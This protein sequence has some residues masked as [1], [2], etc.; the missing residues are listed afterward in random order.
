M[1]EDIKK[2]FDKQNTVNKRLKMAV[3]FLLVYSLIIDGR[4][5]NQAKTLKRLRRELH[6]ELYKMK[7]E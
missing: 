3:A 5:K 1:N 7:G 2:L 4:S 6:K